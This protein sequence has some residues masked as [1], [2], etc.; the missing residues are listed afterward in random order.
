MNLSEGIRYCTML[1]SIEAYDLGAHAAPV[2][3]KAPPAVEIYTVAQFADD[4]ASG[5]IRAPFAPAQKRKVS[6]ETR[7]KRARAR[8]S[9]K[10]EPFD[11]ELDAQL[12]KRF[13]ELFGTTDDA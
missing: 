5:R 13:D 4:V 10:D 6:G 1:P 9:A 3:R 7:G 2:F 8:R 11:A 12:R